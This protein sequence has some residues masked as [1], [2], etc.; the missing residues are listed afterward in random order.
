MTMQ[1]LKIFEEKQIRTIWDEVQEKW[2]FCVADVI[3]A[4]SDS[5]DVKQYTKRLRQRDPELNSV[6]GTIC[7]P[8]KLLTPDGKSN[9]N[10]VFSRKN[11]KN[12]I[13]MRFLSFKFGRGGEI[14][15][16]GLLYP[17]Q[18]RYQTA[19]RPDICCCCSSATNMIIKHL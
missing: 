17:K 19:P 16:H 10:T 7:T 8:L 13:L 15:T 1:E 11:K 18:A 5:T 3:S 2:Y 14:R 12:R 9:S 4:L 6:W